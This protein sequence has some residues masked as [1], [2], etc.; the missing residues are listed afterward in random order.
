MIDL[1]ALELELA[2]F[3]RG[4]EAANNSHDIERVVPFI[5]ED[6]SYWFSDGSYRGINEIRSAVEATFS[7]ILDEVYEVRDLE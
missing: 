3:M 1:T 4:Y 5:A 2:S 7:T 6:A